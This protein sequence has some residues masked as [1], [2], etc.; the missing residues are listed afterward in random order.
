MLYIKFCKKKKEILKKIYNIK[1]KILQVKKINSLKK[2]F[3][4]KKE[5]KNY[6]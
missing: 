4:K 6:T 5:K 2:S 3:L 1:N